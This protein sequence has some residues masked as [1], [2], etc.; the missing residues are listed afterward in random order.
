MGGFFHWLVYIIMENTSVMGASRAPR[1]VDISSLDSWNLARKA[2]AT[3]AL[4]SRRWL[5]GNRDTR[6]H[7][8]LSHFNVFIDNYFLLIMLCHLV[9]VQFSWPFACNHN[10]ICFVCLQGSILVDFY[11]PKASFRLP[12][13]SFITVLCRPPSLCFLTAQIKRPVSVENW[14]KVCMLL[15]NKKSMHVVNKL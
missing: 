14:H 4:T 15:L 12:L 8:P 5:R 13:L 11:L 1:S 6:Y 10:T 7:L 2:W 3:W 9:S